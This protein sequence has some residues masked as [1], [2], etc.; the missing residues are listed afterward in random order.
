MFKMA[1]YGDCFGENSRAL[2]NI[3][4]RSCSFSVYCNVVPGVCPL[5]RLCAHMHLPL[6][7]RM[8]TCRSTVSSLLI[9]CVLPDFLSRVIFWKWQVLGLGVHIHRLTLKWVEVGAPINIYIYIFVVFLPFFD[10]EKLK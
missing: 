10:L 5:T 6:I 7:Q 2:K 3:F 4:V 1:T 8:P 9:A